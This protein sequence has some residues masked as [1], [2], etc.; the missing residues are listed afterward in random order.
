[1]GASQAGAPSMSMQHSDIHVCRPQDPTAIL[2]AGTPT[3]RSHSFVNND[4]SFHASHEPK[5]KAF[6]YEL[7]QT[8][9]GRTLHEAA[10]QELLA[11]QPTG[12]AH[13]LLLEL[14]RAYILSSSDWSSPLAY[15]TFCTAGTNEIWS[16]TIPRPHR[17]AGDSR[18]LYVC[19]VSGCD[20]ADDRP[21]KLL[22]HVATA[23]SQLRSKKIIFFNSC[24]DWQSMTVKFV[25]GQRGAYSIG[26]PKYTA[27]ARAA[28]RAS[29]RQATRPASQA[30]R[31][32]HCSKGKEG[33]A[34]SAARSL[35]GEQKEHELLLVT[36]TGER[37]LAEYKAESEAKHHAELQSANALLLQAEQGRREDAQHTTAQLLDALKQMSAASATLTE[38]NTTLLDNNKRLALHAHGLLVPHSPAAPVVKKR[39]D[40]KAQA[41]YNSRMRST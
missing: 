28:N 33:Q 5:Y 15:D 16:V 9:E 21:G 3:S 12:A 32:A 37:K 22:P 38:N 19:P 8:S 31:P 40:S 14:I 29:R 11:S 26:A 10:A 1:M 35:G 4:A 30:S 24:V 41:D 39:L 6:P 36:A 2:R 27:A 25:P 17:G 20:K 23:H 7:F 18:R 13:Y 34:A